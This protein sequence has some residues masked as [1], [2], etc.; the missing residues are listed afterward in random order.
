MAMVMCEVL[1]GA[2][3]SEATAV[4]RDYQ[5][6]REFLPVDREL[7]VRDEGGDYLPVAIIHVDEAKKLALIALPSEADSGANRIWIRMSNL[8]QYNE[9]AL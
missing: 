8:H 3:D 9:V 7:L 5:N 6:R 4:V 2:R 1:A